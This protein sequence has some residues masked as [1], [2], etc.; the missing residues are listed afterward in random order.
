MRETSSLTAEGCSNSGLD[1]F[2]TTKGEQQ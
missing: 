1:I 2:L